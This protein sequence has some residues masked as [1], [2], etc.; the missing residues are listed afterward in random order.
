LFVYI[1]NKIKN[2]VQGLVNG[3]E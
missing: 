3:K 2:I 1:G